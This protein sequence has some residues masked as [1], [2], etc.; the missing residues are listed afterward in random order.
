MTKRV[1]SFHYTLKDDQG[2]VLDASQ[3]EHPFSFLEGAHQIIPGL[4][5]VLIEMKAG[6][7]IEVFVPAEKASGQIY[8]ELKVKVSRKD[9]PDGDLEVGVQ[10]RGGDAPEDP[11][12]TVIDIDDDEIYMDGNHAL[13]GKDLHFD[14]ELTEI[15]EASKEELEHGHAHSSDDSHH[16]HH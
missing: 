16:H 3:K 8:D 4:E 6:D 2:E 7:K 5:E 15:R 10:F 11:V 13:A 12:Y 1:F 9:L 14:I